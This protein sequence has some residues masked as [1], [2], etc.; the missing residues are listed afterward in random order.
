M[1]KLRLT[2]MHTHT[3]HYWSTDEITKEFYY[4]DS[5]LCKQDSSSFPVDARSHRPLTF[6]HQAHIQ[7]SIYNQRACTG[8]LHF[9]FNWVSLW[10][11]NKQ[12]RILCGGGGFPVMRFVFSK[13]K[14]A[15][16][17]TK[18]KG[19][20]CY[21]HKEACPIPANL[22]WRSCVPSGCKICFN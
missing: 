18:N 3:S 7:S 9:C 16:R 1:I 19:W 22:A 14:T 8:N 20:A 2:G 4:I 11:N 10:L 13:V 21:K 12:L 17:V 15:P 6:V 5:T